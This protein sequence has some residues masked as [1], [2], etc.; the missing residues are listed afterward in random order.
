MAIG[1][2]LAGEMIEAESP[3]H[4]YAQRE[5]EP[6]GLTVVPYGPNLNKVVATHHKY[7]HRPNWLHINEFWSSIPA[8]VHEDLIDDDGEGLLTVLDYYQ[9]MQKLE[10]EKACICRLRND[11]RNK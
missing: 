6:G 10:R 3:V 4:R 9:N 11:V 1:G 8:W 7:Y 2:P 5:D